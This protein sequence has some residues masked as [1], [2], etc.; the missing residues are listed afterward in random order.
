MRLP[1]I[2]DIIS[3]GRAEAWVAAMW[4][5]FELCLLATGST[6]AGQTAHAIRQEQYRQQQEQKQERQQATDNAVG[7][8]AEGEGRGASAVMREK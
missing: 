8:N 5:R 1:I 2:A 3:G 7:A 6:E 4:R